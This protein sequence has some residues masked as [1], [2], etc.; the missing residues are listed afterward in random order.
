MLF[1]LGCRGEAP[2]DAPL[3]GAGD[4]VSAGNESPPAEVAPTAESASEPVAGEIVE[5]EPVAYQIFDDTLEPTAP[6]RV[7]LHMLVSTAADRNQ[8]RATMAEAITSAVDQ[9]PEAVAIRVIGYRPRQT[10]PDEAE[11]EP[12]VWAE[13]LPNEGWY[14][15]TEASRDGLHRMYFYH[16]VA[17]P[18]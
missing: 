18:W 13:W 4:Q 15:A 16:P 9:D 2:S 6:R 12:F 3:P 7:T 5:A 14:E 10:A 11:M 17:P 8:L 1:L